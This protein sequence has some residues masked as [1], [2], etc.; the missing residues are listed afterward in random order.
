LFTAC[1]FLTAGAAHF[2]VAAA[3]SV[4]STMEEKKIFGKEHRRTPSR[5]DDS[6]LREIHPRARRAVSF[7]PL[8]KIRKA[9]GLRDKANQAGAAP[10]PR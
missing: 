1:S 6:A 7:G 10:S 3:A 8:D 2:L 9:A 4:E 5:S